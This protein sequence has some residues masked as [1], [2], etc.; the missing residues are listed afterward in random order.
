MPPAAA[1]AISRDSALSWVSPV[2]GFISA[3]D[4]ML[5]RGDVAARVWRAARSSAPSTASKR[6]GCSGWPGPGK[7]RLY[8]GSASSAVMLLALFRRGF[9][10]DIAGDPVRSLSGQA[11]E[12]LNAQ[13]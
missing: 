5:H 1:S 9:P 4:I 2:E 12:Q 10:I 6:A 7:W 3:L 8:K 11:L 13:S